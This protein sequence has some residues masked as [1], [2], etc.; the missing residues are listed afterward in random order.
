[1]G[2]AARVPVSSPERPGG[3]R[4][5]GVGAA[6]LRIAGALVRLGWSVSAMAA[7]WAWRHYRATAAFRRAL[8]QAGVPPE[9]VARL[10]QCYGSVGPLQVLRQALIRRS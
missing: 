5:P 2:S 4:R 7:Y 8:R 6:G 10:T 1:M 9:A 3:A